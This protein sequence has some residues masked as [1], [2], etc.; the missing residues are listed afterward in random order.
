VEAAGRLPAH[1]FL[2][3]ALTYLAFATTCALMLGQLG[4]P[5]HHPVSGASLQFFDQLTQQPN[6]QMVAF[7]LAGGTCLALGGACGCG[8]VGVGA[9]TRL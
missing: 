7:A 4:P 8:R 9:C 2:D 3:Y 6:W 1:V 5:A